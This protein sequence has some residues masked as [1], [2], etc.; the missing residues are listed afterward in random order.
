MQHK[1][2]GDISNNPSMHDI[3]VTNHVQGG[4]TICESYHFEDTLIELMQCTL[5]KSFIQDSISQLQTKA[6]SYILLMK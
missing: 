3:L 4:T 6:L 1:E 5:R 2:V